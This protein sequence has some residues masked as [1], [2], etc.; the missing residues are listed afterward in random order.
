MY[1]LTHTVCIPKA[2]TK[3]ARGFG[4]VYFFQTVLNISHIEI[5]VYSLLFFS[6]IYMYTR[7]LRS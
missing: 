5:S 1:L 4:F 6:F 7:V 3:I 2:A